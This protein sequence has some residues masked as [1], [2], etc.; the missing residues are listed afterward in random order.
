MTETQDVLSTEKHTVFALIIKRMMRFA[1]LST[2][3][4]RIETMADTALHALA[5]DA[6]VSTT[7]QDWRGTARTVSPDTLRA[8]LAAID[9]PCATA[10]DLAASRV[11][12]AAEHS[13]QH[14]PLL[15]T[16]TAGQ[17][18]RLPMAAATLPAITVL[19][20]AGGQRTLAVTRGADGQPMLAAIDEPGYHQLL[21]GS[22]TPPLLAVAPARAYGLR[23]VV[24]DRRVFGLGAQL[25]SLP[26]AGDGGIGDFGGL[27]QLAKAGAQRG[28][29]A[30]AL[31]PTHA[32]F[33][34]E[35]DR[36]APYSP[37]SRLFLNPMHADPA[38]VLGEATLH[39]ALAATGLAREY[40]ALEKRPL[41]DYGRSARAK[42]QVLRALWQQQAAILQAGLSPLARRFQHFCLQGGAALI[43]H[44]RFE[45]LHGLHAA[46]GLPHFAQW[47]A[48]QR[49]PQS[50]A[51]AAF[52][53][54]QAG[55]VDFHRFAQWLA[56]ESLAAAHATAKGAGMRIG[57][58]SDLAV[59]TDAAGSH[60]WSRPQEVLRG[61]GIG[62][63]PDALAPQGQNWG[64][65]TFSPRALH[66]QGFAPFLEL[67]R[68]NLKHA[69]GIRI[70]HVLGLARLW[71]VPEGAQ[72]GEGAY[73]RYP[74]QDLLRLTALESHRHRA[75]VIGED[76]GTLPE[77][78][79]DVLADARVLG[80]RVLYFQRHHK[81]FVE[82]AR[83]SPQAIAT[84]STHDLPT[85][86]GWWAGRD[87]DWR[88]R[89]G[90]STVAEQAE[91]AAERDESRQFLWGAL[92]YA[93]LVSG[94]RPAPDV[95]VEG[96]VDATCAFIARS[97]SPLVL[98]P[99]EDVLG[100]DEAPNLPGTTSGHPNWQRRL[101]MPAA[102]ALESDMASARL[103]LVQGERMGESPP[104]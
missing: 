34:A 94:E 22:G 87:L 86:A 16:A 68:A 65:T 69:G 29:D 30:L 82:P 70:D 17:P 12:L 90:L 53:A 25:Y 101:P 19:L 76:L 73:L 3:D 75:I 74:L 36:F 41:I 2:S 89:L 104:V 88:A 14:W 59:G 97:P 54:V 51:V 23:E 80:L 28:A 26:R 18:A 38:C 43:D 92:D 93:G 60:A 11:R 66:A 95:A 32:L 24:G 44:A 98:L 15:I 9:L 58:V 52:A 8:L 40:A 10:S 77:G 100:L 46:A 102:T 91:E 31:S 48:E 1:T 103:A 63:P 4:E 83:Y 21:V 71:L 78:F 79:Q 13:A 64:L 47:S 37:S 72:D 57:L 20:E 33:A 6:G 67:L 35:P 49:N 55:E 42:W 81:F 5:Q 85:L 62:A 7:W 56:S 99:V 96:L 45:A 50:V 84:T 39:A 61:V 27:A